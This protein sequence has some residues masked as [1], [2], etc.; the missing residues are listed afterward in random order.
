METT[1]T[2]KTEWLGFC[3]EYDMYLVLH[4]T[5]SYDLSHYTVSIYSIYNVWD[6]EEAYID[7]LSWNDELN[8][9]LDK[10]NI[11][12]NLRDF[13]EEEKEKIFR[14]RYRTSSYFPWE[15]FHDL[16]ILDYRVT[17]SLNSQNVCDYAYDILTEQI[18]WCED[19]YLELEN[20]LTW[21]EIKVIISD[22]CKECEQWTTK[23]SADLVYKHI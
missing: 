13:S 20:S 21:E 6:I 16:K 8:T 12:F 18:G 14:Y 22:F 2:F 23:D 5:N 10:Y 3:D 19:W 4:K 7:C 1:D 11:D 9:I 17:A 15:Y